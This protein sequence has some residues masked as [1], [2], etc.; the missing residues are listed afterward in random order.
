[1]DKL[2]KSQE[3]T[4]EMKNLIKK[5]V[6]SAT[7]DCFRVYKAE[8]VSAPSNGLCTVQ[9][10]GDSTALS[11]PYSSKCASVSVGSVVW[12]AVLFGSFRN[13]VVWETADF[14]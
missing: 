11:L 12:V 3:L 1:M 7:R 2:Q 10:I 6:E 13:A 14:R 9:L 8:V 5:T 4:S